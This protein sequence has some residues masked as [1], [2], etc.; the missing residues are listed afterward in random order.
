MSIDLIVKN[1]TALN[2]DIEFDINSK[3][4]GNDGIEIRD[5]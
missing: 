5:F 4:K 3:E 1:M 2:K